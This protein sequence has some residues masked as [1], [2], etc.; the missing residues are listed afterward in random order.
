[1]LHLQDHADAFILASDDDGKALFVPEWGVAEWKALLSLT[2]EIA[3]P[4]GETLLRQ[5]ESG[6]TLYFVVAGVVKVSV[7]Y[8][9]QAL[10][11]LREVLPGSV[12]GEVAFF[13]GGPRTAK[14]WAVED[15]TLLRLNFED[16]QKFAAANPQRSTELLFAL[17]ALVA[18]RLRDILMRAKV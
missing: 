17:G 3:L 11:L 13:D 18:R 12:L 2:T 7:V 10:G 1:V 15:S 9:D 5:G 4:A 14:V 16:Y 6:R 8:G